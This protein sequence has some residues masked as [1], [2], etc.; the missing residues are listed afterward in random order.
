MRNKNLPD[1]LLECIRFALIGEIYPQIR[2]VAMKYT[3]DK[4]LLL[5][6]YLDRE[7][8]DFDYESIEVVATNFDATAPS[9]LFEKLDVECV[10]SSELGKDL[11][12]LDGFIYSRR[13]YEMHENP[14]NEPTYF[15]LKM[16][17]D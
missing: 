8:T 2:A 10:F 14:T 13:E 12:P 9:Y 7:P 4:E 17:S 3:Q 15:D 11:D 6:Y 1:L 16:L 5:R